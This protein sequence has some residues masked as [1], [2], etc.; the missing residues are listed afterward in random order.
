MSDNNI[1]PLSAEELVEAKAIEQAASVDD[2]YFIE[3]ARTFHS[4]AIATIEALQAELTLARTALEI[5]VREFADL[6]DKQAMTQAKH[7]L[8]APKASIHQHVRAWFGKRGRCIWHDTEFV[9]AIPEKPGCFF[10]FPCAESYRNLETPELDTQAQEL[11]RVTEKLAEVRSEC[12]SAVSREMSTFAELKERR[13]EVARLEGLS[14]GRLK[15]LLDKTEDARAEWQRAE[16]AETLLDNT[17][18]ELAALRTAAQALVEKLAKELAEAEEGG[19]PRY[20]H[21]DDFAIEFDM[22]LA[23]LPK[24]GEKPTIDLGTPKGIG[25]PLRIPETRKDPA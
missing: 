19:L 3:N 6:L 17:R 2:R 13:E 22:L 10:C 7:H 12:D 15:V 20:V 18:D 5:S 11:A 21:A 8:E 14:A 1:M 4:R 24:E 9:E 16:D 23:L 25:Q